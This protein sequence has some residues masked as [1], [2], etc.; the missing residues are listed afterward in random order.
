[1]KKIILIITLILIIILSYTVFHKPPKQE[2]TKK[3]EQTNQNLLEDKTIDNI[4]IHNINLSTKK[5]KS[6]FT[7]KVTNLTADALDYKSL[8]VTFKNKNKELITIV[9]YLGPFEPEEEKQTVCE[10][11]YNLKK[12]NK[13]DF[14]INN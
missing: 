4:N 1:M 6:I 5:D 7:A 3:I 14:S 12:A 11:D 2:K 10:T 8:N 9:C 13:I